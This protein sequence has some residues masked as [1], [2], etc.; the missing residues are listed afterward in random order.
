[1]K[2]QLLAVCVLAA[3]TAGLSACGQQGGGA[4]AGGDKAAGGDVLRIVTGS[5]LSGG[6]A[7]AGK[8]FANGAQLAADEINAKGGLDLGGK[9]YKL[10]IV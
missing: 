9:K 6:Q 1:M 10:E 2:K 7:A 8:D 3:M 5:P 4:A